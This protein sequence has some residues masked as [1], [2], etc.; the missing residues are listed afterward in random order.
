ME[1]NSHQ[2]KIS[3][4]C[5]NCGEVFAK[6]LQKGI[7]ADGKGGNCPTCGV[8]DGQAQVGRFTVIKNNPEYDEPIRPYNTPRM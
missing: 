3:F 5:P 4:R 6:L 1:P 8:S 7:I 2:Y